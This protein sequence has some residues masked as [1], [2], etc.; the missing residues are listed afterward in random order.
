MTNELTS[1][2]RPIKLPDDTLALQKLLTPIEAAAVL[3]MDHRTLVRWARAGY[4]PAHP[5][6]E[7]QRRLWRFFGSELI[8]WVKSQS[9]ASRPAEKEA[10]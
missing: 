1:V 7:G 6:G 10:A 2:L 3:H 4:V 5:L 8:E 9:R